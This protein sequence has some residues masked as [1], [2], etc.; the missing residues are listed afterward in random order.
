MLGLF[1]S[2]VNR[3]KQWAWNNV[4]LLVITGLAYDLSLTA[5]D[6]VDTLKERYNALSKFVLYEV[7]AL[8]TRN[9]PCLGPRPP[10]LGPRPPWPGYI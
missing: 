7:T 4:A 9:R 8:D 10:Y 3:L 1:V 5:R 6:R 2:S